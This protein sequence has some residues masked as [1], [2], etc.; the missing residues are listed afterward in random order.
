MS[1]EV[2]IYETLMDRLRDFGDAEVAWPAV[3]YVPKSGQHYLR[4][5]VLWGTSNIPNVGAAD[6]EFYSGILQIDVF[7]PENQGLTL[8]TTKAK[9]IIEFFPKGLDLSAGQL[10]LKIQNKPYVSPALQEPGW[11]QVPVSIPWRA[12]AS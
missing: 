6:S 5:T 12:F 11:I 7:W 2:I 10:K 9:E 1:S 3:N 8:P 4:P